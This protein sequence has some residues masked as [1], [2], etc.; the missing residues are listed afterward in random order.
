MTPCSSVMEFHRFNSEF[1]QPQDS[2]KKGRVI[3][4]Y[5]TEKLTLRVG[6]VVE[7]IEM[8]AEDGCLKVSALLGYLWH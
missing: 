5:E 3:D 1:I 4:A 7:I 2:K 6:D 8:N